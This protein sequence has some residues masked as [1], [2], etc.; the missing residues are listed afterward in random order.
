MATK[1][2]YKKLLNPDYLGAYA[3]EDGRDIILTIRAVK[4]DTVTGTDS[5]KEDCSVCHFKE[6]VKPMILNATNSKTI[7]KLFGSPYVE[8]WIGKPIQIG[9][10]KVR[11][12]G[13]VWDALRVRPFHPQVGVIPTICAD[14]GASI[15]AAGKLTPAETAAYTH[16]KYGRPLC[17][18]C[19]TAEAEKRREAELTDSA[20]NETAEA[21]DAALEGQNGDTATENQ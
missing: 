8:D 20:A 7:A 21:L 16:Q 14:C 17:A 2:H 5:K 10:E 4:Q 13:D 6:N 19:A 18:R 3:L 9:I 15:E 1:T 11:A 12:F